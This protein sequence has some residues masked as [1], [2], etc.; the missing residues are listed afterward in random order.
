MEAKHISKN[1]SLYHGIESFSKTP[2][3][4]TLK[5]L[6]ENFRSSHLCRVMNP[7]KSEFGKVSKAILEKVNTNLEDS[8]KVKQWKDTDN[9][10]SQVIAALMLLKANPNLVSFD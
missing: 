9:V 5:D 8:L 1:I 3:F 6:N 4:I 10:I 7:S 2:A